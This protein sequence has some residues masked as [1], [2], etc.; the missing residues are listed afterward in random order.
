MAFWLSK[1]IETLLEA[2]AVDRRQEHCDVL[3]V[4]SGYGGAIA[5]MRLAGPGCRVFLFE[6]GK[7]YALG[8]FPENIGEL[9]G[10]V[11]FMRP[12][13]VRPL[14]NADALFDLRLSTEVAALVGNGL[15]GGSLINAN[16]AIE[17]D[18]A[19][20]RDPVWPAALRAD[21][22]TLRKAMG[23]VRA[24]LGVTHDPETPGK[25]RAL[26][27]LTDALG[28]R[29]EAAPISVT[30]T[31]GSNAVGV[32]QEPCVRCGNCI[33]G[34]NVGAKNTLAMNALPLA[35]ER[36]ALI[37]TGATV[38]SVEP[39]RD[40]GGAD[41]WIVHFLR[42]AC[43]K[44][45]LRDELH[46]VYARTVILAAG[47]L[48]STEILLRSRA[49]NCS[50]PGFSEQLGQR[51][52]TNGDTIALGYA[53]RSRVGGVATS[54][55]LDPGV[56]EVGP[57]INGMARVK[58]RDENTG[59]VRD[60]LLEDGAVPASLARVFA[61]L[62]V[63]GSLIKRYVKQENPAWFDGKPGKDPLGI[64]GEALQHSQALLG[65]GDDG[66]AGSLA[67]KTCEASA[68]SAVPDETL[69]II[70]KE[71]K[72]SRAATF[73]GAIDDAL[74]SVE[75]QGF[76][77]GDYLQNPAWSP[78]P[79]KFADEL[80][81]DTPRGP[82]LTVHPLG[83]CPMGDDVGKGA[84]N[85]LGQVF[86]GDGA[87]YAGL[88]VMDG[89]VIPRALGVNPFLTIGALAWRASGK[90]LA[91]KRCPE[92]TLKHVGLRRPPRSRGELATRLEPV[93][94]TFVERLMGDLGGAV[95]AWA[96]ARTDLSF[97]SK[98]WLVAH[99]SIELP[100]MDAW[101]AEPARELQATCQ[102]FVNSEGT[103]VIEP[104]HLQPLA[105]AR[106]YVR[107]LAPDGP[108]DEAQISHRAIAALNAYLQ[109]QGFPSGSKRGSGDLLSGL[110][111]VA[112][113]HARWRVLE[114]DFRFQPPGETRFWV[115]KGRK[116]LAYHPAK[117]DV[118]RALIDLP[119]ELVPEGAGSD[120]Q[121]LYRGILKVDLVDLSRRA[122]IQVREAVH[123]P[124]ALMALISAG[125]LFVR[126]LFQT[127]FWSFGAPDYPVARP[128]GKRKPGAIR[129]R[130]SGR[131]AP[132]LTV[133][134]V[135]A[136]K[137]DE[138][139]LALKLWRYP[140]NKES[141]GES[142]LLVH[143]LAHGA[144]VFTTR[145]IPYPLATY[146]HDQ[147]YEVWLLDHRLSPALAEASSRQSTMDEIAEHDISAAV[148]HVYKA[149]GKPIN[150]FAHCIGAGSF[151][152]SVLGGH[153]HV[154]SGR[155][156]DPGH[157]M[158]KAA[159]IHAVPPWVVASKANRL[160]G[161]LAAFVKD[162]IGDIL[163]DPIPPDA[164][165]TSFRETIV[166]RFAG[167]LPWARA[168]AAPHDHDRHD[169]R[170][171]QA[172]CNRMTLFYGVEWVHGNLSPATHRDLAR[173]VGVG[174]IETFRQI[175]FM[176]Q[177]QRITDRDGTNRYLT[178]NNLR[179][180][181]RF[182][183]L[184][185][186][187]MENQVFSPVSSTR[188]AHRL[189]LVQKSEPGKGRE[190]YL[191]Q[192]SG[193]GHMDFLFGQR[194]DRDV[195]PKLGDFFAAERREKL[196]KPDS[197][198]DQH[199]APPRRPMTGPIIGFAQ[200][201]DVAPTLRIWLEA[202]D[203]VTS[204][205]LGVKFAVQLAD[206][207]WR[208]LDDG[209]DFRRV[210]DDRRSSLA[211]NWYVWY[212]VYDV[213]VPRDARALR[214]WVHYL[215][216]GV[217]LR[218]QFQAI[219][220]ARAAP[221]DA[222]PETQREAALISLDAPW[223]R[224]LGGRERREGC[225]FLAGSCRY[226]GSP[227]EREAADA[228][229]AAM[230]QA[231]AGGADH[232][233][234]LGDQIYADATADA[235]DT[236]ELGERYVGR[237]RDAF[238][239]EN[240]SRLLSGVP[241]Y[242]AIDDHEFSDNWEGNPRPEGPVLARPRDPDETFDVAL[243]AARNYQWTMSSRSGGRDGL[244]HKFVSG[245]LPFF[246]MDTRSQ[247]TPRT[248]RVAP[249]EAALVPDSQLRALEGWLE[250]QIARDSHAPKFIVCG[251]PIGPVRRDQMDQLALWRNCDW[252]FGYPK[253][254]AALVRMMTR[255]QPR[256]VVLVAGDYHFSAVADLAFYCD[257]KQCA[258]AKQIVASGLYA[259]MPFANERPEDF[260][261]GEWTAVPVPGSSVAVGVKAS[262]LAHGRSHFLRVGA[263]PRA[264]GWELSA[265]AI[266]ADGKTIA[267]VPRI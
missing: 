36:G 34:C 61:E 82:L 140:A 119:I 167:S 111:R 17:P 39:V 44:G 142:I 193:Y 212:F 229:F 40:P 68:G 222:V 77:G 190:V 173:L 114:Y 267:S 78:L 195:Y 197:A 67:L 3:V 189:E 158:I 43:L 199:S 214:A 159:A 20:L 127:H 86:R 59:Q 216:P 31:G 168:E 33:T 2:I 246:V 187:G 201:H 143:G 113:N 52:S 49:R 259:P 165:G 186:H 37:Y 236:Q 183:T 98:D 18:E 250:E 128:A 112:R 177:R 51:F 88:Y 63:T 11:R 261:F 254:L 25:M 81:G 156:N 231:V 121:E 60:L 169:R 76:D 29:C 110:W 224:R 23:E 38:H 79:Q 172:I 180:Y 126:C 122:L 106:G 124:A 188:S 50:G 107:L 160:R 125:A 253:T 174:N 32:E 90:L 138:K 94:A 220:T 57:T 265:T 141:P 251:S 210:H 137:K 21:L 6:R 151:A 198:L 153:C 252:W 258:E 162:V 99:V 109:R 15:G 244:W 263:L 155:R 161:N 80:T 248:A 191:E 239:S 205:P 120:Q 179:L 14:G 228:V 260:C 237:Y 234:L 91:Q 211:R 46:R 66:A 85:D 132:E 200:P 203:D 30:F 28:A 1:P 35:K 87:L 16:V 103:E 53:Q 256:N 24:L 166:D 226:P 147:G 42:S 95:P 232:V 12:T 105:S 84:V 218:L 181:W 101:L 219:P 243:E 135:A 247:R 233:L 185:A 27:R 209:D 4:G 170:M 139:P 249:Q 83:G 131:V 245:G 230:T 96:R 150:V 134:Q 123:S 93:S 69:Q 65:M 227:F 97:A 149:A 164:S 133:L 207:S 64:H 58:L 171:G 47:T 225:V 202:R 75:K 217:F 223:F 175:F 70:W 242:M 184:F 204:E 145:T 108:R 71:E 92:S 238:R 118:W 146:L 54:G 235:F 154:R 136:G 215:K 72:D 117:P 104:G 116:S 5:A 73:L 55:S 148:A 89:A 102:L 192:I 208:D 206:G 48:G 144:N 266:G 100:D 7:E 130:K 264:G 241:V 240:A 182:P 129:T 152:M 13:D 26:R 262:L 221:Q 45:P 41:G 74:S 176:V 257:G 8:D 163:V 213:R 157:S 10:H 255:L 56:K 194:A 62:A 22:E 196:R 9:P 19:T 115:L 178:V